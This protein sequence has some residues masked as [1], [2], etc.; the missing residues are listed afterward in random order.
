[1]IND[2]DWLIMDTESKPFF[3]QIHCLLLC[4]NGWSS[5]MAASQI[6]HVEVVDKLL[7]HGATV[8][9]QTEVHTLYVHTQC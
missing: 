6:G 2:S 8:D 7:Q 1:M 5:L 9:L 3:C 4:Q